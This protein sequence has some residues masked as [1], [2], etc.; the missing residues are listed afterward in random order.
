[1]TD[2]TRHPLAALAQ[3]WPDDPMMLKAAELLIADGKKLADRKWHSEHEL[4]SRAADIEIVVGYLIRRVQALAALEAQLAALRAQ[5]DPLVQE[6]R[7]YTTNN[8]WGDRYGP[9]RVQTWA[10]TLA[11]FGIAKAEEEEKKAARVDGSR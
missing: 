6:M 10:D 9:H 5:I 1:M 2:P 4:A 8:G 3:Q 11:T 7:V